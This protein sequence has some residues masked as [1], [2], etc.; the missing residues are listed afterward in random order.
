MTPDYVE[1]RHRPLAVVTG[2]STG[3][4]YELAKC[5]AE[6][7]FDL[8]IAADESLIEIAANEIRHLDSGATV[9][10]LEV[11]L[12]SME[13][14]AYLLSHVGDRPVDALLAN[15]GR[16]LGERFFD[17]KLED[18]RAVIETN[19]LGTVRLV[20]AIGQRMYERDRGRILLTGSVAGVMPGGYHT[21]YNGTKAFLD[22][23]SYGLREELA[24]SAV[25]LTCLM[26]GPTETTF[27]ERAHLQDTRMG[28]MNKDDPALVAKSGF[29]AMM[30]GK[31]GVVTG[32]QNK[33]QAVAA[34]LA[35]A[36]FVAKMHGKLAEPGSAHRSQ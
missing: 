7:G 5:C 4:G 2:A 29:A 32:W 13:G 6:G 3:I 34:R 23:F 36:A 33:L 25:T 1:A 12:S 26:P 9:E 18:I 30:E 19:V 17:Q 16:G 8:I 35:P 20:H 10:A 28:V 31:A 11:D 27:F 21:V 14:V 22:N 15:A 24:G